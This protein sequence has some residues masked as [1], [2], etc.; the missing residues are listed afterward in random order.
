MAIDWTFE[1]FFLLDMLLHYRLVSYIQDGELITDKNKIK[2]NYVTSRLKVD[3]VTTLPFDLIA[4]YVF[5]KTPIIG[6]LVR[7]L[8]MIRLGRY[9]GLLEKVFGFL[10]DHHMSLAGLKLIEFLSGVILI[11]HW[12]A[13]GFFFI[14]RVKSSQNNC[15]GIVKSDTLAECLWEGTWINAQIYHS[16]LP[17][18][19]GVT[20]QHY[21]RSFNWAL[22]TLV[23][24]V[25]GDVIPTTS[26]E[27]LYAF[28]LMAIGV[29]VNAAIVGNVANIVANLETDSSDFARSVDDVRNYISH[30]RLN[31][32]LH[33]RVDN[34]T[35]YLW[36]AHGGN[37]NEDEFILRLPYTLQTD[38]IARTRTQLLLHCPFFDFFTND[39]VKAL[40]LCLKPRQFC[41][42]D[43][44]VHAGDFGQSMFFLE[45]GT[46]Q[47]VPSDGSTARVLVTLNAGSFFGETSV[48]E[49]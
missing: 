16:K 9:F 25:I 47:A 34:F 21:I 12:A 35:R 46:V 13:C 1:V 44:I 26:P 18:D 43:I 22:P 31:Y 39:T 23:V 30:H 29:T 2:S 6:E 19:G 17:I 37:T 42:A 15:S 4:H 7:V 45:T 20:W 36:T 3:L 24:V 38:V 27:T 32:D 33:A 8:K 5:P 14:A 41:A 40:A 49:P 48:R 10:L 28:L 11:A